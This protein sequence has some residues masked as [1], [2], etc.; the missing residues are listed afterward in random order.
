MSNWRLRKDVSRAVIKRL[1]EIIANAK[2]DGDNSR[3]SVSD[4]K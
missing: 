3:R 2:K 4:T 1:G